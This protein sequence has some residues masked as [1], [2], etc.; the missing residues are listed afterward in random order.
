MKE[1]VCDMPI[2]LQP[3]IIY[4]PVHSRRL[5]LSLGINILPSD[6]KVCNFNCVYCQYGSTTARWEKLLRQTV[7]PEKDAILSE[8]E[9]TLERVSNIPDYLTIA[10]NGEPTAHPKFPEIVDGLIRLRDRYVPSAKTAI[11]S[12]ASLLNSPAIKIAVMKLDAKILKLDCGDDSLFR[13]YNRPTTRMDFDAILR[14][15]EG[16]KEVTIQTLFT[17]GAHGNDGLPSL[18]RWMQCVREIS[19]SMV[20]LYTLDRDCEDKTLIPVSKEKLLN[21]REQLR[22]ANILAEA[23]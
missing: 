17:E 7:W 13:R 21:I 11:L 20:Q 8:I 19:P 5:G 18:N 6:K 2:P 15:L 12:N 22:K 4:G 14:D 1:T 9:K 16:L 3:S 23:Y 10:G